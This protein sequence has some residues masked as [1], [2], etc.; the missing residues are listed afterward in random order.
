MLGICELL[1]A[2]RTF[3]KVVIS[4]LLKGHTHEDIDAKFGTIWTHIWSQQ[5][6]TPNEYVRELQNSFAS[7]PVPLTIVDNMVVPDYTKYIK[8]GLDPRFG[9]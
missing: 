2:R 3:T 1:V 6:L 9:Q 8:S 7:S 4:Y 5:C